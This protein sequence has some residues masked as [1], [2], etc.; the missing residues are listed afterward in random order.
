[1]TKINFHGIEVEIGENLH[2]EY[3]WI[4]QDYDG[5]IYLYKTMPY[6]YGCSFA[7]KH[8]NSY[9]LMSHAAPLNLPPAERIMYFNEPKKM[10]VLYKPGFSDD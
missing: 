2:E 3:E 7:P 6:C 5:E 9:L 1:M 4:A 10:T 8:K